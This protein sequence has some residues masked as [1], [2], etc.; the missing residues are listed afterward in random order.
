MAVCFFFSDHHLHNVPERENFHK[1]NNK[2]RKTCTQNVFINHT[3]T[4]LFIP[5]T[6]SPEFYYVVCL[7]TLCEPY[8]PKA[9]KDPKV[10]F[11]DRFR[12]KIPNKSFSFP[13]KV[14][15]KQVSKF[16][17]INNYKLIILARVVFTVSDLF[18]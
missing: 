13:N 3:Y 12:V 10:G 4:I 7:L 5:S 18:K 14:K 8:T 17:S 15:L 11:A 9:C 6:I 2:Q 16:L 1:Y